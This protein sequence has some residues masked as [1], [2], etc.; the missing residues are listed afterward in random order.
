MSQVVNVVV[1]LCTAFLGYL[2]GRAWQ[3]LA[4]RHRHRKGRRFWSPFLR[5]GAQVVISR[6]QTTDFRVIASPPR[7]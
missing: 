3:E 6:V 4:T 7:P 5:G 2:L 1:G